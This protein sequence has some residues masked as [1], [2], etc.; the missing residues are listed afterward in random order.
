MKYPLKIIVTM[1]HEKATVITHYPL[2]REMK[3]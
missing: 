2:K 1:E 3:K